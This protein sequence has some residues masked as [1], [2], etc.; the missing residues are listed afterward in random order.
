M[1]GFR[2]GCAAICFFAVLFFGI[3]LRESLSGE[4]SGLCVQ[5]APALKAETTPLSSAKQYFAPL[6]KIRILKMYPHDPEAFTQGLVFANGFLYESTGLNG[7]SSLR[8]VELETGRV[9]KKYSLS[10]R[11]FAEGLTLWN[12]SA[13]QLTWKS[14]KGFVY[15]LESFAVEREFKYHGEGWGLTQ[16]GKSLIMSNGTEELLFLDP[17]RLVPQRSL[18]VVDKGRPVLLLN[19][20]EYIKG[21][22]FANIWQKDVIAIISPKTGEVTGWLDMSDLRKELPSG[23]NAEALNGIAYDADKGRIFV[24]G[25]LWPVLFE[26]EIINK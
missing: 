10:P 9:I 6:F 7:K 18:R 15:N 12:G 4:G 20:L 25:K 17:V 8:K 1:T 2:Y 3:S 21:E 22:I 5:S 14:G 23:S 16:D 19:E 11:Y 26:I 13:V 24:T